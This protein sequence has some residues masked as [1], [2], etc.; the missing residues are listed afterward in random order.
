LNQSRAGVS[1][2]QRALAR[3]QENKFAVG[4]ANAGRRDARRTFRFM[5]SPLGLT[6]VHWDHEP[7]DWSSELLFGLLVA[8][9]TENGVPNWSS[10]LRFMERPR[11]RE[12]LPTSHVLSARLRL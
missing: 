5:E 7:N 3:E 4:F 9:R 1:P 12:T 6:T 10:A 11:P 8:R 2:A